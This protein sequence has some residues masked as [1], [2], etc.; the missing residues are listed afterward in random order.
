MARPRSNP[1]TPATLSRRARHNL[2]NRNLRIETLRF[3]CHG[4]EPVCAE[5]GCG[6]SDV[7]VLTIDHIYDDGAADRKRWRGPGFHYAIR[8]GD[9]DIR[10]LQLLCANHNL[11]KQIERERLDATT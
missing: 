2:A 5:D 10:R 7:D 4:Q 3:I 1:D 8:R 9:V 11:K 6:V